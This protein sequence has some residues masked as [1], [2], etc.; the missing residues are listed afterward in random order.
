MISLFRFEG[1]KKKN[2]DTFVQKLSFFWFVTLSIF[3]KHVHI[4][5]YSQQD[6]PTKTNS[7]RSQ[8]VN[9]CMISHHILWGP[10]HKI[11]IYWGTSLKYHPNF[12]KP[13]T[14]KKGSVSD[15]AITFFFNQASTTSLISRTSYESLWSGQVYNFIFFF[16]LE[17]NI[18]I[19]IC[20]FCSK[21]L[22][23]YYFLDLILLLALA[24]LLFIGLL[25]LK[26]EWFF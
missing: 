16:F 5:A 1:Q 15:C 25:Y 23:I 4:F 11:R 10:P 2:A 22:F 6:K 21:L 18:L 24:D 3:S 14:R 19:L 8:V 17:Y 12:T 9:H 7:T 26:I 20:L 13:E